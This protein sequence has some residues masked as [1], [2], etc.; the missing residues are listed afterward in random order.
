MSE[1]IDKDR[2]ISRL[3][4]RLAREKKARKEAE[5][6]LEGKSREIYALNEQLHE[7]ARLLEA[8]VIN[9]NDAIVITTADLENNGPK[10]VYVNGAFSKISGY[11]AEEIIGK[12]PRILQGEDTSREVLDALKTS[13][14]KGR[15]FQGELKNYT[16]DGVPYW[17][18]ISV[19][20]VKDKRGNIT[21][22]AAIER[23]ITERKSFEEELREEKEKAESANIAKSEF[24]ANMSH[25]LRTPLNGIIGMTEFILDSNLSPDQRDNA[26]ILHGSSQNLLSLLNDILDISKIEAGELEIE[27]V[28]FHIGIAAQ[29]VVQLFLP[30]ANDKGLALTL[31]RDEKVPS[32]VIGDYSRIQQ[33]LR[34]LIS[35]A[36]KFTEKGSVTV[37]LK[38]AFEKEEPYLFIAVKDT[39]IGIAE[40]KKDAIF[41]K[42]TQ[43]DTS[44]T[45]E[46][47][48]TGLG[49]AITQ[50]LINMMGGKI[51]VD[52]VEGQG[53][54][55]WFTV[56]LSTADEDMEPV[57]LLDKDKS[58]DTEEIRK[59]IR[60]LAVDDHPVNQVFIIKLLKKL[61]FS[62]VDLAHDGQEALDMIDANSYDVVLMDCQ[63]PVLDGYHATTIL[64]E[65]EQGTDR[66]LPV[67][68][69]TA[70]AMIGDREKCLKAGM[71]DYVSKPV[72][73]DKII[74]AIQKQIS[75]KTTN[76]ASPTP[77][78]EKL[79]PPVDMKHFETFTDGDP[80]EEKEL[81]DLFFKQTE[82]SIGELEESCTDDKSEDWQRAAHRMKGAAA[83]LGANMLAK[84]CAEAE[85]NYEDNQS[86]KENM[87]AKIKT[88]LDALQ[89]FFHSRGYHQGTNER[90]V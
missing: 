8:A 14:S 84:A 3:E 50:Q 56:P 48:G 63:M 68:A 54:T 43:A 83:N 85:Q 13:L 69:L 37:F 20:P 49:L 38:T 30:I 17:L 11:D 79:E 26:E 77:E 75:N 44:V 29:Q 51:G 12:T 90:R 72:K 35:N 59:N 10:I 9:A 67:I 33:V 21:H 53:S 86:F 1:D 64:R 42:F 88:R 58:Y 6:L 46:F 60:I 40:N 31:D 2:K 39:G 19:V 52:S 87:L 34:N 81:L 24:L 73:A 36:I 62:Y 41:E 74:E 18:D 65:K 32:T 80:E 71:D 25:E 82:L 4:K 27:N 89:A 16:K 70:N 23:N 22:F 45:R 15:S 5:T 7:D 61:G 57:N 78:K 28:P 47:G 76:D 66:H 55:F